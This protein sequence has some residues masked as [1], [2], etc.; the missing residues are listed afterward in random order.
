MR[1]GLRS[2]VL[3]LALVLLAAACGTSSQSSSTGGSTSSTRSATPSPSTP[4][5]F[6]GVPLQRGPA[7]APAGST[8][9]GT[10]D[11][12]QCLG[13]EQLVYHVHAHLAVYDRGAPRALPAGVGIPGSVVQQTGQGPVAAGGKCI[14]WLHT[15]TSDGVIHIESPTR[16]IY[17]LGDLFDE[18]HQPL[19]PSRVAVMAGKVTAFVN[20]KPWTR[21][22]RSIPLTP[23]AVIQLDVGAPVVGAQ[24]MSWSQTQL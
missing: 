20:G 6:E 10:V 7:L 19:S 23:H 3:L 5:G 12:V 18:W 14:Y 9:T 17:T 21:D 16:R 13:T 24:P 15:H 8:Q 4:T 22:P 11:G 2:S 1:I